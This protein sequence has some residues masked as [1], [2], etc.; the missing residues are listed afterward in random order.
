MEFVFW[1]CLGLILYTYVGYPLLLRLL[2]ASVPE[3]Q[4][5]TVNCFQPS[6]PSVE[7][8]IAAYNE[9]SCIRQRV[10][11]LLAQDY[12][13]SRLTIS[14]G[15]DGSQ[16]DTNAILSSI[17]HPALN[18][19]LFEHNRGKIS[20]LNQLAGASNSQILVFSD[21]NTLFDDDAIR[22]LVSV[23][24]DPQ[25]GAVSGELKLLAADN[26]ENSD[27]LYWRYE[28]K[29]KQWESRFDAN[30]GANG[31]IYAIRS[32]LY[33]QLPTDTVVDDF[34]IVMDIARRGWKVVYQPLAIAREPVAGTIAD[35][36]KRRIRIG[37]GNY[38]ALTRSLWALNPLRGMRSFAFISHKLLRWFVPHLMLLALLSN[39]LLVGQPPY[40]WLMLAQM[41]FYLLVFITHLSM[42]RSRPVGKLLRIAHFFVA[43]NLSLLQGFIK[44][45]SGRVQGSWERTAR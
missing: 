36:R 25:V 21:A 2:V 40:H 34:A 35:E 27:G 26:A 6:L 45:I 33:P 39:L 42:L 20:V 18:A 13:A 3:K 31:G 32:A 7:M 24:A 17:S 44:F 30:L 12:P 5:V 8:V 15:S 1:A 28:Q 19:Q 4:P 29:L 9:E 22:Q 11:N 10:E 14:V 23:F 16:D 43:M 38:Q 37:V 41:L